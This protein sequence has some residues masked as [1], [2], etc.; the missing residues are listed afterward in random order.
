MT[1]AARL[2]ERH[3]DE[4][5]YLGG[6][7]ATIQRWLSAL[8]AHLVRSRPRLLLAQALMAA[9]AG[10]LEAVGPLLDAAER[11]AAGP[12]TS[13]SSP[14]PAGPPACWSTSRR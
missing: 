14:R 8:P 9:T 5:Y 10:T 7:A 11:A 3:F 12:A 6:E 2:I 13:R 1:R 4:L